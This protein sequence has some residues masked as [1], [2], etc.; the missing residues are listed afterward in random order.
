MLVFVQDAAEAVASSDVEA[1]DLIGIGERCGRRMSRSGVGEVLFAAE[2]ATDL[3]GLAN[4]LTAHVVIGLMLTPP[5]LVKMGSTGGASSATTASTAP[6][7][8]AQRP[9]RSCGFSIRS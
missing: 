1:G 2:I 6:I 5:V 3:L 7:S 9:G 8:N 4:V